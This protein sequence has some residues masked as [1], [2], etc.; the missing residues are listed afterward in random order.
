MWIVADVVDGADAD[1]LLHLSDRVR[2]KLS[3][4]AAVLGGNAGGK[5]HLLASFDPGGAGARPLGRRRDPRGRADR[6][7]RRRRQAGA[8]P[9]RRLG[10]VAARGGGAGRRRPDPRAAAG[11][12]RMRVLAVDY[13]RA[14]TGLAVSDE[15][16]VLARPVAVVERVRSEAGM[17]RMLERIAELGPDRI[18]V[19]MPLTLRGEHGRQAAE[20]LDFIH[21]LEARCPIPIETYDERFTTAMAVRSRPAP[22][23]GGRRGG[24]RPP[25]RGVSA[26]ARRLVVVCRA[27]RRRGRPRQGRRLGAAPLVEPV[28]GAG[29]RPARA[30]ASPS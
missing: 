16:G 7:R 8:G 30:R 9:R 25:P 26:Q 18:V 13:G 11:I 15:T 21:E 4:A 10:P 20:T 17:G 29:G 23:P 22:R 28:H 27:R 14:R 1:P 3:P 12:A 5:A 6:L 19:G 2:A 24:G